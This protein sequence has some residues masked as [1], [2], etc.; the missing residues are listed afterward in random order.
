MGY[1]KTLKDVVSTQP[2]RL[3]GS[4][5]VYRRDHGTDPRERDGVIEVKVKPIPTAETRSPVRGRWVNWDTIVFLV[6]P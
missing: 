6:A 2:F 4:D 1:T 5:R 3:P